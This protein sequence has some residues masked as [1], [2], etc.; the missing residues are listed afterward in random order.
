MRQFF[1]KIHKHSP[2]SSSSSE[3]TDRAIAFPQPSVAGAPIQVMAQPSTS[4]TSTQ[5]SINQG[6]YEQR[7]IPSAAQ[8]GQTIDRPASPTQPPSK[9]YLREVFRRRQQAELQMLMQKRDVRKAM[10]KLRKYD[11][12]IIVDDSLSMSWD[13]RWPEARDALAVLVDASSEWDTDGID[14]YFLNDDRHVSVKNSAQIFDLFDEV[15]PSS[16]TPI[17]K[18]L[19]EITD[20]YLSRLRIETRT[21]KVKPAN[22]FVITDGWPTDEPAPVI[23]SLAQTLDDM[24][25]PNKQLGIQFVQIGN[26][27]RAAQYLDGL[28]SD[29]LALNVKRDIVD[30]TPFKTG[31]KLTAEKIIKIMKGGIDRRVDRD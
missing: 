16:G 30:S 11:I 26:D 13:D 3:A 10:K 9:D 4:S 28:D 22:I 8:A 24:K 2:S 21:S 29:V 6:G 5:P 17:A 15:V 25:R 20:H 18:R 19:K 27:M 12:I 1:S 23:A 7:N 31:E 14:V